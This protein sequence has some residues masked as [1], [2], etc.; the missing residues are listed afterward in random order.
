MEHWASII[1]IVVVFGAFYWILLRP[2]LND[3]KRQR[4]DIAN[5]RPGDRVITTS[6]FFAT[7]TDIHVPDEG[8]AR[9]TLELGPGV[10]VEALTS[11][12]VQRLPREAEAGRGAAA[13]PG[14]ESGR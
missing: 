11:A 14:A 12:I 7:V 3:R 4:Q 6:G 9:L 8:P 10:R 2:V 13:Q 1:F 5:L